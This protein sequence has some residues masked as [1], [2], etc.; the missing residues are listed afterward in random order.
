MHPKPILSPSFKPHSL[1]PHLYNNSPGIFKGLEV[2]TDQLHR[3]GAQ[4]GHPQPP[5]SPSPP[6]HQH[7][8]ADKISTWQLDLTSR[9]REDNLGF[10]TMH[11]TMGGV[12]TRHFSRRFVIFHTDVLCEF[13]RKYST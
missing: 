7:Q 3:P 11:K 1:G 13:P 8:P 6:E 9:W 4:L 2:V 10:P 12:N 5:T